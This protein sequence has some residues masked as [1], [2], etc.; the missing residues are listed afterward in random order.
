LTICDLHICSQRW[1]HRSDRVATL[2]R[3]DKTRLA[4]DGL[5]Q[6]D[7]PLP[8]FLPGPLRIRGGAARKFPSVWPFHWGIHLEASTRATR[9]N[10]T[11]YQRV[12]RSG[13][14][15]GGFHRGIQE[16]TSCWNPPHHHKKPLIQNRKRIDISS[17]LDLSKKHRRF[18]PRGDPRGRFCFSGTAIADT[19]MHLELA[20]ACLAC[21]Q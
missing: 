7:R 13:V 20:S 10:P 18:A 14:L 12:T 1:N 11:H 17:P 8:W 4:S 5:E 9:Q 15:A 6:T 2:S 21:S 3:T 19:P 16:A